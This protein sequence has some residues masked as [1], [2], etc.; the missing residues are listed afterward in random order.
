M[1]YEALR[2]HVKAL[3]GLIRQCHVCSMA[4]NA[5]AQRSKILALFHKKVAIARCTP[6]TLKG[7]RAFQKPGKRLFQDLFPPLPLVFT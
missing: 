3:R 5:A 1:H 7:L 6:E 4:Q 2:D